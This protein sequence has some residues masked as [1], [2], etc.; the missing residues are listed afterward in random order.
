MNEEMPPMDMDDFEQSLLASAKRDGLA[1]DKKLALAL[2]LAAGAAMMTVATSTAKA[3]TGAGAATALKAKGTVG[4]AVLKWIAAGF[5]GG[6]VVVAAT[7]GA[8]HIY[9]SQAEL[10]TPH[11]R[12]APP[13]TANPTPAVPAALAAKPVAAQPPPSVVV[14]ARVANEPAAVAANSAVPAP[15]M[16]AATPSA[17][18]PKGITEELLPIERARAALAAGDTTSTRIALDEH[19]RS[20]PGGTFAEES[21][22]LRI[23]LHAKSGESAR[24]KAGARAYLAAH[25]TSPYAPRLRD[26]VGSDRR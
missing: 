1:P 8:V 3:A 16:R 15:T 4:L 20:F 25:P 7:T 18:A 21:R 9:D 10:R 19:D 12:V 23:D 22:V 26:L 17:A 11:V 6:A 2:G 5:G 24:A 13:S 14:Q